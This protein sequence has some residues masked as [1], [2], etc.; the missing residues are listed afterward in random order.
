VR[1]LLQRLA[2]YLFTAWAAITINFFIPRLIPGDPVMSRIAR[3]QGQMST[4]AIE[5]LYVLSD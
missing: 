2:F 1:Y 5:S 4:K 3:S